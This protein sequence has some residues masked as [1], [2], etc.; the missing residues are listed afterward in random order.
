V[1]RVT[2]WSAQSGKGQT[3]TAHNGGRNAGKSPLENA[4]FIHVE[5]LAT[6][7]GSRRFEFPRAAIAAQEGRRRHLNTRAP[8]VASRPCIN[9]TIPARTWSQT[10]ASRCALLPFEQELT[11]SPHSLRHGPSTRRITPQ[12]W[13]EGLGSGSIQRP[14][15]LVRSARRLTLQAMASIRRT[16]LSCCLR[17][18]RLDT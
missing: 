4:E 3:P 14:I 17:R 7:D 15:L 2:P 6:C 12:P 1:K 10:P 16:L 13:A 18:P 5:A 11:P 8:A 9:G